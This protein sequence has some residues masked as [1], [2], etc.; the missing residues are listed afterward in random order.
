MKSV[1]L[2]IS[3][4]AI[5]FTLNAQVYKFISHKN[6]LTD[7]NLNVKT[8]NQSCHLT[9]DFNQKLINLKIYKSD[10][11]NFDV[12]SFKMI[13]SERR[14]SPILGEVYEIFVNANLPNL[15][16]IETFKFNPDLP[17]VWVDGPGG[18]IC[19]AIKPL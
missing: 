17:F 14:N 11:K 9:F 16:N 18:T 6:N 13:K 1:A 10:L 5:S 15:K 8:F 19:F 2:L 3:I 7:N 12:F 4:L